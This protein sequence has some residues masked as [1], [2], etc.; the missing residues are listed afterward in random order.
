LIH[1]GASGD[2]VVADSAGVVAAPAM[3]GLLTRLA[4]AWIAQNLRLL[5]EDR[6]ERNARVVRVRDVRERVHS[7]V[8]F[9]ALGSVV[10]PA[11]AGDSLW[12]VVDLYAASSDYPL[13]AHLPFGDGSVS[14]FQHAGVAFVEAYTGR[15]LLA[16]DR[17]LDPIARTWVNEFPGLFTPWDRVPAALAAQAPPR[18]DQALVA[19][20]SYLRRSTERGDSTAPIRAITPPAT[21]SSTAGGQNAIVS[22]FA[23]PAAGSAC[24]WSLPLLD[25]HERVAGLILATGGPRAAVL[26]YRAR[27][28][29]PRWTQVGDRLERPTDSV[30]ST[31][32][33]AEG[34]LRSVPYRG[35]VAFIRPEYSWPADLAPDLDRVVVVTNDTTSSARTLAQ[36]LGLGAGV[37]PVAPPPGTA[38][39]FRARVSDLYDQMQAS[40]KRGDL[41]GFAAQF[42]ELGRILGRSRSP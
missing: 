1:V 42:N 40:L 7:L 36:A 13:S 15:V 18:T 9:F 21:D 16:R 26:R 19:A 12:W 39:E 41:T 5:S 29:G 32:R 22:C 38:A 35:G 17:T 30:V 28:E 37:R 24:S 34:R 25:M 6:P 27:A 11:V 8:P 20:V 14:Y 31:N 4:H 2:T 33:I 10:W 23:L 3:E